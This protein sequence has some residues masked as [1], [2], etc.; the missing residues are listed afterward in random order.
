MDLPKICY[1]MYV[2]PANFYPMMYTTSVGQTEVSTIISGVVLLWHLESYFLMEMHGS[3]TKC[4]KSLCQY[5]L[6][7]LW[8]C[9]V[10]FYLKVSIRNWMS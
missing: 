10:K 9:P 7:P 4:F 1:F 8:S 2:I 6:V 3:V 5:G